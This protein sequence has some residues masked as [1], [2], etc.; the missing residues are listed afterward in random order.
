MGYIRMKLEGANNINKM[1]GCVGELPGMAKQALQAGADVLLPALQDAAPI[2]PGGGSHIR[3]KLEIKIKGGAKPNALVGV[4]GEPVAYYVE[5]GHG[6]P[7][8]APAH[9]YMKPT[10]DAQED[11][12]LEAIMDTID[13]YLAGAGL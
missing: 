13:D 4:W 11:A 1:L 9:P 2:G 5:Y 12:V 3:D 8:P 10:V 6:G 7:H